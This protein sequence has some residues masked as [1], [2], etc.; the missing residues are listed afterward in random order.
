MSKLQK[1]KDL[2]KGRALFGEPLSRHTSFRI[3]GP[4][5][6]WVEPEDLEDLKKALKF[7][8]DN[9]LPWKMLGRGTNILVR[10]EGFPGIIISLRGGY[11][12]KLEFQGEKV[13]AGAGA[14]LSRL[15]S[16]VAQ[17]DLRGLEFA[18]GIPGTVG[19]AVA[20]NAGAEGNSLAEVVGR[21]EVLNGQGKVLTLRKEEIGFRYRGSNLS[22]DR[23]ILKAELELKKGDRREIENLMNKFRERRNITQPLSEPSAGSI[24]K[25]PPGGISAG[26]LIEEAH[27][28]G[29]RVGDAQI[30]SR[31][32]NFI[33]NR[34]GARAKD[35]ISLVKT[36]RKVVRE[37]RGLE[38]ELEIEVIGR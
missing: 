2:V 16:E 8:S 31:H 25:N 5:D 27:L 22:P 7:A 19:G 12:Q 4:A 20:M 26:E 11:F 1:I 21:I 10:D 17:R 37:G 38:L 14:L 24:F 36:I 15:V 29:T 6:Y 34:G 18:V 32:A 33:V 35:V 3:G 30:S 9:R 23:I 28:K 13:M